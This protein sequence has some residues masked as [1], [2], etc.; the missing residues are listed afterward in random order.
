MFLLH[1]QSFVL[2]LWAELYGSLQS[3]PELLFNSML[4][5]KSDIGWRSL[6][7]PRGREEKKKKTQFLHSL[8]YQKRCPSLSNSSAALALSMS[9]SNPKV[10]SPGQS[11]RP[12]D[13]K[14]PSKKFFHVFP[15]SHRRKR[16]LQSLGDRESR[17]LARQRGEEGSHC[18]A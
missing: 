16:E 11:Q 12:P 17:L 1:H 13:Q 2:W 15:P 3:Q 18:G 9:S 5:T 14:E 8:I 10:R 7:G 6:S 4:S